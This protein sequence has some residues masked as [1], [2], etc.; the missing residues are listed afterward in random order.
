MGNTASDEKTK[1]DAASPD[2]KSKGI[3]ISSDQKP[4]GIATSPHVQVEHVTTSVGE[5]GA[6][7]GNDN[8]SEGRKATEIKEVWFA[9][10]HSDV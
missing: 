6:P 7:T 3:A 10:S 8:G 5:R 1:G 9:G 4:K 2:E